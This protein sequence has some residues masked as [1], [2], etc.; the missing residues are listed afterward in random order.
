MPSQTFPQPPRDSWLPSQ[1]F[2]P[3]LDEFPCTRSGRYAATITRLTAQRQDEAEAF[4]QRDLSTVDQVYLWA[5]ELIALT[6]VYREF[7]GPAAS[8]ER[9]GTR[10]PMLAVGDGALG[11]CA[12]GFDASAPADQQQRE[13]GRNHLIGHFT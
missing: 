4:H 7:T 1:D 6:E 12:G 8:R 11:T 13:S 3:A 10:A 2:V 5:N 9:R